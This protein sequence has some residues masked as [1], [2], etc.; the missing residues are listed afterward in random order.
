[1]RISRVNLLT[2]PFYVVLET[3]SFGPR[4]DATW[5]SL[6]GELDGDWALA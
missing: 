5:C 2:G 3:E 6:G 1:M 4:G